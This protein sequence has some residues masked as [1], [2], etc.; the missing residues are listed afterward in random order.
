MLKRRARLQCYGHVGYIASSRIVLS[1]TPKP[2]RIQVLLHRQMH[3]S[4]N[5]IADIRTG[6]W[7]RNDG[8]GQVKT[9]QAQQGVHRPHGPNLLT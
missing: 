7:A 9:Q 6:T 5:C 4:S 2:T 3:T 8:H 1:T